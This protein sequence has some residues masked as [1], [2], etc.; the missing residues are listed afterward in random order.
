MNITREIRDLTPDRVERYIQSLGPW[1]CTSDGEPRLYHSTKSNDVAITVERLSPIVVGPM[2][3]ER[4]IISITGPD[5]EV[6][7]LWNR[8]FPKLLRGGA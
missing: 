3:M 8:L 5:T 1:I 2:T 7:A 4:V 6:D